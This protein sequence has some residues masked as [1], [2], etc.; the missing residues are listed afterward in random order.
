MIQAVATDVIVLAAALWLVWSFAPSSWRRLITHRRTAPSYD[1]ALK[2][3]ELDGRPPS[4][5]G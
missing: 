2:A 5:E 3:D 1:M 4:S